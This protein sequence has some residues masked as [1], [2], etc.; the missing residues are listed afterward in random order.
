MASGH[1]DETIDRA[2][3][4]GHGDLLLGLLLVPPERDP[5]TVFAYNQPCTY[6]LSAI[7][8]RVSGG[9]LTEYL[10]PRLF[11]PLG[12]G[13]YCW[14]T[15]PL[16]RELGY[17]GLHVPT[18]AVAR[19][20]QLYL[21]DGEW[22]GRRLLPPGW[23]AEASRVQVATDRPDPD[24]NQG[25]GFQFWR[26]R[27][28][29]RGDGAYGQFMV[30]LPEADAVVAITSQSPDMQAVLDALWAHLLPALTAGT[31]PDGPWPAET[32]SLPGPAAET[33]PGAGTGRPE[34]ALPDVTLAP[35]PDNEF[36]T[37]R[38]VRLAGDELTLADTGPEVVARLGSADGWT[39]SGPV[40]TAYAWRGERLA[41]DVVFVDTPHRLHLLLDPGGGR[42]AAR[43]QTPPI[44]EPPLAEIPIPR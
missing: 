36:A 12:I 8:S 33:G 27:H 28:G 41:V 24:W 5:G 20:G 4:A 11:E 13:S 34:R 43:W 38:T 3:H 42:F 30:I 1:E 22:N 37:L 29:Y 6:A 23:V 10:R 15:D 14:R 21:R 19:L 35:G 18:E 26:S 44:G 25:Y 9:T 31:G 17:S 39:T 16:G 40:A 2:W 7:I 32:P